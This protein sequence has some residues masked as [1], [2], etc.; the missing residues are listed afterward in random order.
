MGIG[1][2]LLIFAVAYLVYTVY[3][4]YTN[5]V[6]AAKNQQNFN[7][8]QSHP[9]KPEGHVTVEKVEDKNTLDDDDF[10]DYEEIK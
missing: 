7:R 9:Q 8:S 1:R 3:K 5:F 2:I 6:S 4:R 10:E